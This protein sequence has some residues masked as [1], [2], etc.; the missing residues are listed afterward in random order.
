M[1][2]FK[3]LNKIW[4]PTEWARAMGKKYI[5]LNKIWYPNGYF[6]EKAIAQGH[7]NKKYPTPTYWQ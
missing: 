2:W 4:S 6:R 5:N 1:A 3:A 7:Y